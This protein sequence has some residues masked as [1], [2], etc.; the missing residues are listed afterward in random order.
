MVTFSDKVVVHYMIYWRF[1]YEE[2]R[3]NREFQRRMADQMRFQRRIQQM[4]EL[5]KPIFSKRLVGNSDT[6][7]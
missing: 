1:A 6:S 2:A 3:K 7:P 5:L 4:E